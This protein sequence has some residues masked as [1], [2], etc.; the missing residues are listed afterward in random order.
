[1]L[2]TTA[3]DLP[4]TEPTNPPPPSLWGSCPGVLVYLVSNVFSVTLL[5]TPGR[6]YKSLAFFLCG[7]ASAYQNLLSAPATAT[8]LIGGAIYYGCWI[9]WILLALVTLAIVAMCLYVTKTINAH[10]LEAHAEARQAIRQGVVNRSIAVE[11]AYDLYFPKVMAKHKTAPSIGSRREATS[12]LMLFPGALL[13]H[14]AYGVIASKLAAR[15]MVVVVPNCD[16]IRLPSPALGANAAF[17]VKTVKE[18]KDKHNITVVD[19]SIGGHSLGAHAAAAMLDEVRDKVSKLVMWGVYTLPGI[20]LSYSP[21]Q[22]LLVTAT[23]DGFR[24]ADETAEKNLF[25]KLPVRVGAMEK[26][27]AGTTFWYDVLG[28]NHAGFANY[29]PQLYYKV[30][31]ERTITREE[32]HRQVVQVVSDFVMGVKE[33]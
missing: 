23:N 24:F 31:G 10:R 27:T 28:G 4:P 6:V 13:D 14:H 32:Q 11:P 22:I 5:N 8:T 16:P 21:A 7:M 3:T 19:W 29:G 26:S 12:G 25:G 17:F 15:G 18:L 30:D 33:S 20:N 9:M 1:M 2:K